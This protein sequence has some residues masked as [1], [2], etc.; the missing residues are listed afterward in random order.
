MVSVNRKTGLAPIDAGG[1]KAAVCAALTVV[2]SAVLAR[3]QEMHVTMGHML[4][5]GLEPSLGQV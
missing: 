2:P 4:R 3:F 1:Q 5:P